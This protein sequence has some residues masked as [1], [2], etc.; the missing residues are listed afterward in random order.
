MKLNNTSY[1]HKRIR[2]LCYQ[3]EALTGMKQQTNLS[4]EFETVKFQNEL[5]YIIIDH[6]KSACFT[7]GHHLD[8]KEW[9]TVE[10]IILYLQWL[11]T[12]RRVEKELMELRKKT[13]RT[14]K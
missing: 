14:Q 2:L 6:N 13:A 4:E 1:C 12:G 5:G 9:Q 7:L 3:L 11:E 10:D 8:E